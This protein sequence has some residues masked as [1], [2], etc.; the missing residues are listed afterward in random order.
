[1]TAPIP[2]EPSGFA[3]LEKWFDRYIAQL[4]RKYVLDRLRAELARRRAIGQT[5]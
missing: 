2:K 3:L 4:P 5:W 1:M